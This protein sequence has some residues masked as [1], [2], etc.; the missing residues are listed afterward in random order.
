VARLPSILQPPIA[1]AHRGASAHA[2]ANTLE[3]FRL[4]LRLGATGLE[5]DVWL[6]A[7]GIPVLDHDG[8]VRHAMR[9]KPIAAM[10]RDELPAHIPALAELY[11]ECGADYELSLDLKDEAAADATFAVARAAGAI[12]RLW[13]CHPEREV[14][15]A[16]RRQAGDAHLVHSTRLRRMRHGPERLAAQLADDGI[17]VVNLHRSD[18][19]GGLTTLFHRFGR[20]TFG[21]DAQ[22]ERMIL[23]LLDMGIDAVYS[24]HVDRLMDAVR[25][26]AG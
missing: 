19:S 17:E 21:W 20:L 25:A 8:R 14:L 9:H 12:E 7:D 13:L 15:V 18:W 11:A 2:P 23:E 24:N 26:R 10:A 5:S 22:H 1:F 4:G 3:A 16:L 6:T